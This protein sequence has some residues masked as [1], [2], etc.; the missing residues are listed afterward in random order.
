MWNGESFNPIVSN[1]RMVV[2]LEDFK[3]YHGRGG[4]LN[5]RRVIKW[6]SPPRGRLKLNTDGSFRAENGSGG[7]GAVIRDDFGKCIGCL[8]RSLS[9]V[10]TA[11]Q[12]EAKA[13]R[14]G[15]LFA[16]HHGWDT[17]EVEMDCITLVNALHRDEEDFSEIGRIVDDCNMYASSFAFIQFRHVYRQANGV[18]NRL[19]CLANGHDLD[20]VWL[21]E[22]PVII[23]D[24]LLEDGCIITRGLG[25][26]SPPV[27]SNSI[28]NIMTEIPP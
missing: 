21:E 15:M 3:K 25:D 27:Y 8:A 26:M 18:A 22:S 11:L 9:H 24:I 2:A 19:A 20:Q 14:T 7:I 16:M 13:L 28:N 1:G 10:G 6:V 5:R 12:V 4:K 17:L 23:R